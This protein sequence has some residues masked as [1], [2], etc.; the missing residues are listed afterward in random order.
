MPTKPADHKKPKHPKS[1]RFTWVNEEGDVEV[2]VPFMENLPASLLLALDG[3]SGDEDAQGRAVMAY[4]FKR[5][6]KAAED[7]T[8]S[9][10]EK[11]MSEWQE[12]SSVDSGN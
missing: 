11:F 7:M 6:P 1:E 2:T 10:M 4:V 9:E 3:E 5:N 8:V 12:S